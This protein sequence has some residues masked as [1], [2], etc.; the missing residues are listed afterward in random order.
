MLAQRYKIPRMK[1]AALIRRLIYSATLLALFTSKPF[2][3]AQNAARPAAALQPEFEAVSIHMVDA[4]TAGKA[5][6]FSMSPFPTNLFTMRNAPLSF[7]IQFA[8]KVDLQDYISAMPG[9]M[10]SQ[11]YDISAKVEGEQQLTLEQTRPMLQHM[12]AQRFHLV[13]HR[14]TEMTSGFE[15]IVAKGGPK[16]RA[17]KDGGKPFAQILSNRIE[18]THMDTQH[19]AGILVRRAGR[20]VVDKTGLTGTY[21]FMLSYAPVNDPVNSSVSAPDASLPDFFT[22]IQ[23]QLGL[24]LVSKKVPVDFLVIDHV[25]KI[26]TEN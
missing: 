5:S 26:P 9:W 4:K 14:E 10:E 11:E 25:D 1:T 7:L 15:L 16:L 8:Y 23:E 21:D 24:K 2:V 17:S 6:R 13:C 12:L 20:P 19:L 22:A 18:A 3:F